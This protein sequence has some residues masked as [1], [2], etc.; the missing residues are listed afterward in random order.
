MDP[1]SGASITDGPITLEWDPL[2]VRLSEEDLARATAEGISAGIRAR[3]RDDG[4]V[5]TGT[6]DASLAE[7]DVQG[8]TAVVE[9][10]PSRE[11]WLQREIEAGTDYFDVADPTVDEAIDEALEEFAGKMFT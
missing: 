9:P 1:F 6:L 8:S 3:L 10:D 4:H 11:G 7:I 2:E 5:R